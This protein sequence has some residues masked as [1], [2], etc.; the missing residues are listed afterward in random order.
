MCSTLGHVDKGETEL[1][2]AYR[3]TK[4]ETGLEATDFKIFEDSKQTLNYEVNGKPKIVIY[5][6]AQLT[7]ANAS[8]KL[9]DEHINYKWLQ[10][11]EACNVVQYA[12]T[13][14]LLK[15]CEDYISKH[16]LV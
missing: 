16:S 7:N 3:E 6:L 13:Q 4:E 12:E 15:N 9:S 11:Q 2:T 10:L 5:W 8:V 1:Q 14:Q